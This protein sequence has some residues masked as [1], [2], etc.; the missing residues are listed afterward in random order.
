MAESMQDK[1]RMKAQANSMSRSRD[2][3][4]PM[5][6]TSGSFASK[7]RHHEGSRLNSP[8]VAE[9]AKCQD[10]S[11]QRP[12]E[13]WVEILK[14]QFTDQ[15]DMLFRKKMQE[16]I[17]FIEEY[18]EVKDQTDVNQDNIIHAFYR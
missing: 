12:C 8:T 14:A 3:N 2:R 5:N 4:D 7:L 1:A 17:D 18:V 6:M 13:E 15:I 10:K 9:C 16:F 11:N